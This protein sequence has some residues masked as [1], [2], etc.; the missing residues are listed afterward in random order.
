MIVS[1]RGR[2]R[3]REMRI[4]FIALKITFPVI[5]HLFITLLTLKKQTAS[6]L[7]YKQRI[8]HLLCRCV[9][10]LKADCCVFTVAEIKPSPPPG[11]DDVLMSLISSTLPPHRDATRFF[12]CITPQLL[13]FFFFLLLL[14]FLTLSLGPSAAVEPRSPAG[15]GMTAPACFLIVSV[16]QGLLGSQLGGAPT[17]VW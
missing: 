15:S 4:L 9:S 16:P 8:C 11:V 12:V 17:L 14:V 13:C 6:R 7:V 2:K 10:R 1:I 5:Y 3:E